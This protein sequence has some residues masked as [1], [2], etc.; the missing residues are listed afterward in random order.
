MPVVVGFCP[1]N[2]FIYVCFKLLALTETLLEHNN[3][4]VRKLEKRRK[5][6]EEKWKEE[7]RE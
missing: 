4:E 7:K 2:S 1:S 6:E 5:G 3:Y